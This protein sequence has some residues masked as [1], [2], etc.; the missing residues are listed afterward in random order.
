VTQVL[1]A[2]RPAVITV[3]D[4]H[5]GRRNEAATVITAG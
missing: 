3:E 2:A 4:R 1:G 5:A